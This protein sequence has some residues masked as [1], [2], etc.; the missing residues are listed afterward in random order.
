MGDNDDLS[1]SRLRKL[2]VILLEVGNNLLIHLV[3]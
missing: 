2:I 1:S 3:R